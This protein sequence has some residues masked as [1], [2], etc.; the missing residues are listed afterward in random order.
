MTK[1]PPLMIPILAVTMFGS[2]L[3][4]GYM[5]SSETPIQALLSWLAASVAL[6]Y[7]VRGWRVEE[8]NEESDSP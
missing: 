1:F 5:L 6:F 4:S 8:E 7:W 3:V 2:G